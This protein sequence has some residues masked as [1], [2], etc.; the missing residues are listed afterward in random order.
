M[1][2]LLTTED[3]VRKACAEL[4]KATAIGVDTETTALHPRK[5][6]LRLVQLSDGINTSILDM[7]YFPLS[8]GI[9]QPLKTLLESTKTKKVL[10][11]AK[12]DYQWLKVKAG[13]EPEGIFDT[14]LADLVIAAATL[15]INTY[16]HGLA[17]VA[18]RYLKI[19][20]DKEEQ[21]SDWSGTLSQSQ[22]EYAETDVNVLPRL[23]KAYVDR[24]QQLNLQRIAKIEFDAVCAFADLEINGFATDKERYAELCEIL[25]KRQ[26]E[27]EKKLNDLIRGTRPNK[28][29]Q[30]SLFDGIEEI[31]HGAA[32]LNSYVQIREAF[33]A[34][35]V[36]IFDPK[37]PADDPLIIKYKRAKKPFATS[38]AANEIEPLARHYPI[39]EVLGQ[40]RS[41]QKMLSSYGENVLNMIDNGRIYSNFWQLRAETGRTSN[42]GPN[43][44]QVPGEEEFRRCFVAPRGRK[45][46]DADYSQFELRILAELCQDPAMMKVF[47]DGRD[48][49]TMTTSGVFGISY[50][51][52]EKDIAEAKKT[53]RAPVYDKQRKFGK[54]LNFS[55]AYG[56]SANAYALKTGC[57]EKEAEL[58]L[59]KFAATYPVMDK[60]L[61]DTGQKGLD[62]LESVT[63]AGRRVK[64]FEPKTRGEQG[65]VRRNAR[66]TPIQGTNADILKIALPRIYKDLKSYDAKLVHEIHDEIVTESAESCAEEVKSIMEK[67]M[68]EAATE[69]IKSVPVIA[70]GK[71]IDSWDKK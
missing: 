2:S 45:L 67:H 44:Q 35:G 38:T 42:T 24:L 19:E 66:N 21:R 55:V 54:V 1:Y 63:M 30:T 12:F 59:A 36:P 3:E 16:K 27:A 56:I 48:L 64:F 47:I 57:S 7:N 15:G 14:Y 18:R 33:R 53:K 37:N 40:Y 69:Y 4:S 5:G 32:N 39:L 29:I 34:L 43:L 68:V 8:R 62:T 49:H 25:E 51:E 71:I 22:L 61:N 9:L 28:G 13:I 46:V 41:A 23:R 6:E 26:K 58:Y 50:D 52:I 60:W 65:G 17:D 70:E 20:M 10:H 31:D 11:N